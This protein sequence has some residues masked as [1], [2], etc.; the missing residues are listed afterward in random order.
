MNLAMLIEQ[1]PLIELS[2]IT[3]VVLMHFSRK[4]F[5]FSQSSVTGLFVG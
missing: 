2:V 4:F 5:G 3:S 1:I